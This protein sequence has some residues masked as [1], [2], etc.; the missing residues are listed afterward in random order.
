MAYFLS[1]LFSCWTSTFSPPQEWTTEEKEPQKALPDPNADNNKTPTPK[2]NKKEGT[3]VIKTPKPVKEQP[4]NTSKNSVETPS[5]NKAPPQEVYESTVEWDCWDDED[6]ENSFEPKE[7]E[8]PT[9]PLPSKPIKATIVSSGSSFDSIVNDKKKEEKNEDFEEDFFSD[10]EPDVV[11]AKK[12]FIEEKQKPAAT[13]SRMK[14]DISDDE[15]MV[16]IQTN[17]LFPYLL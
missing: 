1:Q 14:M 4:T 5:Q 8:T 17:L 12:I 13:S 3:V 10:M 16:R 6:E 9:I 7:V 15:D 2:D 11:P